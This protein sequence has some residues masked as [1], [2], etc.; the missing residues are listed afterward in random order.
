M[1]F[2]SQ[3]CYSQDSAAWLLLLISVAAAVGAT[4][5]PAVAA[6][7]NL[8]GGEAGLPM[9]SHVN[10]AQSGL[11]LRRGMQ[12]EQTPYVD[13][14]HNGL[15]NPCRDDRLDYCCDF[16]CSYCGPR[17]YCVR[18]SPFQTHSGV[19]Q[20]DYIGNICGNYYVDPGAPADAG[21]ASADVVASSGETTVVVDGYEYRTIMDGVTAERG[22]R[23]RSVCHTSSH[24][25]AIPGG[26]ELAPDTA[27]VVS[28]VV[29]ANRW[30]TDVVVL[31]SMK[32]Y[33]TGSFSGETGREFGD[34][35]DKAVS[36]IDGGKTV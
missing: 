35:Q 19:C 5:L 4:P 25:L 31:G 30:A 7:L 12:Q 1:T 29:A 27:D 15:S 28:N 3:R 32:A 2:F 36:R 17:D 23:G 34:Y 26:Y 33:G 22:S 6:T 9:P 16:E 18:F 20:P 11:G 24:W 8:S 14:H 13:L 21:S 10:D